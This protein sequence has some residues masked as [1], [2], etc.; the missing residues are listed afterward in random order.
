MAAHG[1]PAEDHPA[2]RSGQT[3][4]APGGLGMK[5]VAVPAETNGRLLEM[6][7]RVP[8]GERLVADDHYHPDGPEVWMIVEGEAGYRLDGADRRASAPFHYVVP[9]GISHGHPWNAGESVLI[10]RQKIDTG[11]KEFPGLTAGV[12]GYFETVFAFAQRGE[13]EDDGNI[14]GRFQNTLTINDL[15]LGGTYLAG[16]PPWVQR[17]VLGTA[18]AMARIGGLSAYSRPEFDVP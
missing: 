8:P 15:L 17:A 16:P 7:W 2:G 12:Q 10:V 13:L 1:E 9:G 4:S 18:A 11:G 5:L 14:K 6:E 3:L